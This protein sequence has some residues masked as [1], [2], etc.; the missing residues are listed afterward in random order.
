[1]NDRHILRNEI[2]RLAVFVA[3]CL[4]ACLLSNFVT[5]GLKLGGMQNCPDLTYDQFPLRRPLDGLS[6]NNKHLRDISLPELFRNIVIR[7]RWEFASSRL[8]AMEEFQAILSNF[9]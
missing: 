3:V 5:L 7:D 9:E 4:I 2:Y 1:M 8:K 6:R